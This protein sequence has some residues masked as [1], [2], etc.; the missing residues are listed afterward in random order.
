VRRDWFRV[1]LKTLA[2]AV[3]P[4]ESKDDVVLGFDGGVLTFTFSGRVHAALPAD[5][6]AWRTRYRMRATGLQRLPKRL[7]QEVI[8]VSIWER[9]LRIGRN[10]ISGVVLDNSNADT[11]PV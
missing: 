10:V 11:D 7:M 9:T 4:I 8:E 1:A 5:G 3:A 6:E 2:Q